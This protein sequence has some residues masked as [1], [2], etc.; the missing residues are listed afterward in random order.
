MGNQFSI[1]HIGYTLGLDG[2]GRLRLIT[3]HGALEAHGYLYGEVVNVNR[4]AA[5]EWELFL[6]PRI[7]D[8][9]KPWGRLTINRP[10]PPDLRFLGP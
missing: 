2:T 4:Q 8:M 7:G 10:D 6:T 1:I 3:P 9:G 5:L